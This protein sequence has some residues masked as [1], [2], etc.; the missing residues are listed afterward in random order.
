[1]VICKFPS[2]MIY[3][4]VTPRATEHTPNFRRIETEQQCPLLLVLR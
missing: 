4:L 2:F 3:I 1:V